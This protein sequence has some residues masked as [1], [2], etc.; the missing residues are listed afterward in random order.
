MNRRQLEKM[1]TAQLERLAG[2]VAEILAERQ[3]APAEPEP[4]GSA[5]R[6]VVERRRSGAGKG[7]WLQLERVK[8]GKPNCKKCAG[9]PAHGPYWY[10]YR[11]NQKTGRQTSEYVGKTL[12][13][14]LAAE[15][16]G[17]AETAGV[18]PR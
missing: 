3:Q 16:P 18:G 2:R 8:C 6:E 11:P 15:F 14:E 5:S 7:R 10:L 13:P 4:T 12:R 1:G 9:G 17:K